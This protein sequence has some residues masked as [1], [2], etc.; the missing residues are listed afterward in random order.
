MRRLIPIWGLGI[1]LSW[2]GSICPLRGRHSFIFSNALCRLWVVVHPEPILGT[3][4]RGGN[5]HRLG[6]QSIT[7]YIHSHIIDYYFHAFE[8]N[9]EL[10]VHLLVC[11]VVWQA[12]GSQT[13]WRKPTRIWGEHTKLII[14]SNPSTGVNEGFWSCESVSLLTAPLPVANDYRVILTAFIL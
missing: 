1:F 12:E 14:I 10:P 11:F 6:L 13:T 7:G 8:C 5:P 9:L 3:R 2:F 4:G